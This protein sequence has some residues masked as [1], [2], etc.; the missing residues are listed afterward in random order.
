M[1]HTAGT[2]LSATPAP[3]CVASR[4]A[5][6]TAPHRAPPPGSQED[7]RKKVEELCGEMEALAAT[8]RAFAEE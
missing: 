3:S 4:A 2:S 8:T 5:S 6:R 7:D 1:S